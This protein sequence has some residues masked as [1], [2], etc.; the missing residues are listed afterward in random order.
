ML[1]EIFTFVPINKQEFEIVFAKNAALAGKIIFEKD[2]SYTLYD[3][4]LADN[5][6][7]GQYKE[8]YVFVTIYRKETDTNFTGQQI[9][10]ILYDFC[11]FFYQQAL[12]G[13]EVSW[14]FF[15]DN[16][17]IFNNFV[18]NL[19]IEQA[20]FKTWTG[21][22]ATERGFDKATVVDMKFNASRKG[23]ADAISKYAPVKVKFFR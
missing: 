20:V 5:I 15:S 14:G 6:G 4:N 9:F 13:I 12:L 11:L 2:G 3:L 21:Q 23:D 17:I 22:R 1:S 8:G 19:P 7:V 18:L 16:T 10:K